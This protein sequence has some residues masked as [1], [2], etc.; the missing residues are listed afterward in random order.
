MAYGTRS[1]GSGATQTQ[2]H[3]GN[4]GTVLTEFDHSHPEQKDHQAPGSLTINVPTADQDDGEDRER[5]LTLG[6]E[7][8]LGW[9]LGKDGRAMSISGL[10]TPMGDP[11]DGM[12]ESTAT[13][14]VSGS[15]SS[16]HG[17]APAPVQSSATHYLPGVPENSTQTDTSVPVKTEE[18]DD[19]NVS[20]LMSASIP[21]KTATGPTGRARGDS[22]ASAFLNGI[23]YQQQLPDQGQTRAQSTMIAHTPPTQMGTSYENTHFGKRMRSGVSS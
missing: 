19:D 23:L 21:V 8:D 9:A 22:T 5:S 6:S 16:T 18:E 1:S 7:F 12:S 13:T 14:H 4:L 20:D 15:T 17:A 3:Q 11:A 2:Q 10:F